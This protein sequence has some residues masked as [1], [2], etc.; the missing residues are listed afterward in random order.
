M[1]FETRHMPGRPVAAGSPDL[2]GGDRR[3]AGRGTHGR[4]DVEGDGLARSSRRFAAGAATN[5]Y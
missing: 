4:E 5:P 1:F 2:V 3:G